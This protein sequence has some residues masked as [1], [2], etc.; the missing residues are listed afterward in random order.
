MRR[1]D[2]VLVGLMTL[3]AI[4]ALIAGMLWLARGGLA[5]G[6]PLYAKFS[7]GAGLKQGQPVLFSGAN[8]GYVDDVHLLDNGGLVVVMKIYHKQHVPEKS[9]AT[10]E[11]NGIFGD[12]QIAVRATTGPTGR[13][14]AAGDTLAS[15]PTGVALKDVIGRVD[16]IATGLSKLITALHKELI[17]ERAI[18]GIRKMVNSADSMFHAI[19]E[20]AAAQSKELTKTQETLRHVA[21]A[22]DSAKI[23]STLDGF[24][25][26]TTH[27]NTLVDSLGATNAQ[28]HGIL[29]KFNSGDGSAAR[30][31][32]SPKMDEDLRAALTRFNAFLDDFMKN[33]KKYIKL[34]IF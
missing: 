27:L 5:S 9:V 6:Y 18:A 33:P 11:P 25:D 15:G 2:E 4:A 20:V 21:S 7:W 28:I 12:Q 16:S 32:N 23:N 29:A 3:V 19:S 24:R 10:I 22:V 26:A 13:F 30:L 34:T 14:A 31:L 8:I 17:D 1:R